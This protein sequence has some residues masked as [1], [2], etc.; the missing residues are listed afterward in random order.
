MFAKAAAPY[1][2]LGWRVLPLRKEWKAPLIKDWVAAASNDLTVVAGWDAKFPDCNIGLATGAES[3]VVVLDIDPRNGGHLTLNKL[4]A[5]GYLLPPCPEVRTANKGRHLYFA[6]RE[7]IGSSKDKLGAGVDVQSNGRQVVLPPSFVGAS[8]QGP[9]SSYVW[10]RPLKSPLPALPIWLVDML[11]PK[12]ARRHH[13]EPAQ[14]F[15]S[16]ERSLEGMAARLASAPSGT[17]NSIL[18]WAAYQ[19]GHLVREHKI[20]SGVVEARLTQA[21][22]AAGLPLPEIQKTIRSGLTGA[23]K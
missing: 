18:N 12:P 10:V 15:A 9:G 11:K 16:A 4:A 3:G 13:F 1:L 2:A 19:A 17:R 23:M 5:H 7:G 14:T 8:T 6:Y 21:A 20:G 22:L